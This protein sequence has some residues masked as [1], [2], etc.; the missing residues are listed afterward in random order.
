MDFYRTVFGIESSEPLVG[1]GGTVRASLIEL[2]NATI[3]LLEPI[4]HE[5]AIAKFL[6]KRGEGI[7]HVCY[8]VDDINAEIESLK[9]KGIDII[10]EP[11]PGAEGL[12]V[13][14]HPRGTHGVLVELVEKK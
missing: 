13:F 2:E 1:G 4:G 14:L 6:E 11:I 7:H 12:S 3:E 9:E 10:G 8:E 5:G